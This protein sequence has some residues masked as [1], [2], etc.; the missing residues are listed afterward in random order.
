MVVASALTD[1]FEALL[2]AFVFN[3]MCYVLLRLPVLLGCFFISYLCG[4]KNKIVR[5]AMLCVDVFA[6]GMCLCFPGVFCS[7]IW[8]VV[9]L[10]LNC[11][12]HNSPKNKSFHYY[13]TFSAIISTFLDSCYLLCYKFVCIVDVCF[14]NLLHTNLN[15]TVTTSLVALAFAAML[16]LSCKFNVIKHTDVKMLSTKT[17]S[18]CFSLCGFFLIVLLKSFTIRMKIHREFYEFMWSAL[19]F[20]ILMC[21][22]F[23]VAMQRLARLRAIDRNYY[24]EDEIVSVIDSPNYHVDFNFPK[25]LQDYECDKVLIN[26]RLKKFGIT[27]SV[28]GYSYLVLCLIILKYSKEVTVDDIDKL[29]FSHVEKFSSLSSEQVS[30]MMDEIITSVRML[31]KLE[32]DEYMLV[33]PSV[34]TGKELL[35]FLSNVA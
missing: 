10:V 29:V 18:A 25:V 5:T 21:F 31:E 28:S 9:S 4:S 3:V 34:K 26:R 6:F 22:V 32:P 35:Y 33:D 23:Y 15:K 24:A 11:L 20:A 27:Y 7:S 12:N 16:V 2:L 17:F 8:F 14:K 30:N 19:L 1:Q 13:L